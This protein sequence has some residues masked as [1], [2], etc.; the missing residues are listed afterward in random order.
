MTSQD[1]VSS[2]TSSSLT[3]TTTMPI[4]NL[5]PSPR[6]TTSA[7]PI[8]GKMLARF[9]TPLKALELQT[10]INIGG[11]KYLVVPAPPPTIQVFIA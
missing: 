6:A 9:K 5:A 3:P 10:V 7:T 8:S 11:I 1:I 2:L 4:S